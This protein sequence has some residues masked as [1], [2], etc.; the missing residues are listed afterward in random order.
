MHLRNSMVERGEGT[1]HDSDVHHI[2]KIAH[3]CPGMKD[4][5]LIK[6]LKRVE[7]YFDEYKIVPDETRSISDGAI[8]PWETKV[9][10]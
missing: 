10:G 3:K 7:K 8:K 6:N 1:R 9:F 4:K 2:P 5:A